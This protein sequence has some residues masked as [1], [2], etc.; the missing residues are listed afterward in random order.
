MK[1]FEKVLNRTPKHRSTKIHGLFLRTE[2]IFV[3]CGKK[4]SGLRF[5]SIQT[6]LFE[7]L[8]ESGIHG[9]DDE[10]SDESSSSSAVLFQKTAKGRTPVKR[11]VR[12]S[13]T[14]FERRERKKS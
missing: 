12:A 9:G 5:R 3:I 8:P 11:E 4:T 7:V 14:R 2:F 6:V 1:R 10:D 13:L